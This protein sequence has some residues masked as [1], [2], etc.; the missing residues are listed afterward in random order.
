MIIIIITSSIITKMYLDSSSS[1][2]YEDEDF[3]SEEPIKK[4]ASSNTE[5]Q[6]LRV[7][8]LET[9]HA[10]FSK[11][12]QEIARNLADLQHQKSILESS[13]SAWT[14]SLLRSNAISPSNPSGSQVQ[15]TSSCQHECGCSSSNQPS[16]KPISFTSLN[17]FLEP[18]QSGII[19]IHIIS[20][21]IID[22]TIHSTHLP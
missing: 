10:T 9:D 15:H 12:A 16:F 17:Q 14:Q 11:L 1:E 13:S 19:M 2:D 6:I 21:D 5:F 22:I 18:A 4:K 7:S 3:E 20:Y 8:D